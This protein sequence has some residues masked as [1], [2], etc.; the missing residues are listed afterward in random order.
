MPTTTKYAIYAADGTVRAYTPEIEYKGTWM[1][2]CYLTVTVKSPTPIGF[3]VGD[4][5]IYRN[6]RF[7]LNMNAPKCKQAKSGAYGE[8]FVYE[9][10][11]FNSLSDELT[12][13]DFLDVVKED[14]EI[15]YTQLPEFSFYASSVQDLADRIQANLDRIYTGDKAWTVEVHPEYAEKTNVSV[16]VSNIKVWGALELCVNDFGCYFIVRNRTIIIGTAGMPTTNIFKF[17][18]GNGL[19]K[20]EEQA[21]DNDAIITRLRAY[22]NTTNMPSRYYNKILKADSS[23]YLPNNM[24]VNRLMLPGFPTATL[25]PY[26]G[27]AN[28]SIYGIREAT[29]MFDGSN[30][31]DDIH[32]SLEGMTSQDL[33]DA[34][35]TLDTGPTYYGALDELIGGDQPSD[36]G[37]FEEDDTIENIKVLVRDL[38]FDINDYLTSEDATISFKDGMCGGRE[39]TIVSVEQLGNGTYRI[40]LERAYDESLDMYFPNKFYPLR[41]GDKF[42]IL[43]IEMPD[44]YI[45]AA[46]QRLYNAAVA[47]LA[48]NDSPRSVYQPEI[49]EHYMARQHDDYLNGDAEKSLYLTIK[50]GDLM[51]FED[52][53]L[54]VSGNIVIDSLTITEGGDNKVPKYEITLREEKTVGTIEK[55]QNQIDS[56][57]KGQGG[58]NGYNTEQ[59]KSLIKTLGS[60][61]YLSKVSKDTAQK[62]IT[63]VS[64][65]VSQGLIT[66]EQG[67][68]SLG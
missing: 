53:D 42:V 12:R 29:V 6:E 34:G 52:E 45:Q 36:D 1:G 9:D 19:S 50:E 32:P 23:A 49:D 13:C 17:G 55:L 5:M 64:G 28:A 25:D 30:D 61:L 38:G 48:K 2:E 15:H 63:F 67:V 62:L 35:I 59:L 14:N 51:L 41:A 16:S 60:T 58:G 37:V 18:K 65:L 39:M 3:Q 21:E 31:L 8:A 47:Y 20:I 11:K 68:T 7:E 22:G 10:I 4:Y 26:I 40:E 27:S 46:S 33:L 56:L 54:G 57:A 66:A 44:V 24:A 43:H